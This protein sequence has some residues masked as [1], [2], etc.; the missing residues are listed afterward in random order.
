MNP[1]EQPSFLAAG[2]PSYPPL[3]IGITKHGNGYSVQLSQSPKRRP[4]RVHTPPP[5]PL[6]GMDPDEIIDQM[7][8]GVGA[9]L[10][11]FRDAEVGDSWKEGE[12]REKVRTAFKTMFPGFTQQAVSMTEKPEPPQTDADLYGRHESL[13]FESKES[14]MK[15]LDENLS[16]T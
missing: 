16:S 10:R 15:Y 5:N 2:E 1:F 11:T 3:T 7:I 8:D 13:V 6:E 12:D 9:V 14:L 4:H